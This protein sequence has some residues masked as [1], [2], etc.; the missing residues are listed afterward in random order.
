L[1]ASARSQR[2]SRKVVLLML[3]L[4]LG[5]SLASRPASPGPAP[6]GHLRIVPNGAASAFVI[7]PHAMGAIAYELTLGNG[8]DESTPPSSI[9]APY[10]GWRWTGTHHLA[11]VTDD[12]TAPIATMHQD[13]GSVDA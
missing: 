11:A 6:V 4:G 7:A 5:L 9:G 2:R 10:G 8:A 13:I 3:G 1:H 12:P